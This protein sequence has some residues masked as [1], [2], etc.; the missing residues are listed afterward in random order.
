MFTVSRTGMAG[1]ACFLLLSLTQPFA[2]NCLPD[3]FPD[4]EPDPRN[5]NERK[6]ERIPVPSDVDVGFEYWTTD[7]PEPRPGEPI[8]L[9][10]DD[11]VLGE[12]RKSE[13]DCYLK[14]QDVGDADEEKKTDHLQQSVTVPSDADVGFEYWTNGQPQPRPGEPVYLSDEDHILGRLRQRK[15]LTR[16]QQDLDDVTEKSDQHS[17]AVPSDVDVGFEYWTNGQPQPSPGVPV[18]LLDDDDD[19]TLASRGDRYSTGRAHHPHHPRPKGSTDTMARYFGEVAGEEG[20]YAAG[21]KICE[22]NAPAYIPIHQGSPIME[23][24]YN[25]HN[26]PVY[27]NES[28][29]RIKHR[30][31]CAT[32]DSSVWLRRYC[33]APKVTC[34]KEDGS[35]HPWF[36]DRYSPD[37]QQGPAALPPEF[38]HDLPS[39]MKT[40][41]RGRD[42]DARPTYCMRRTKEEGEGGEKEETVVALEC[43]SWYGNYAHHCVGRDASQTS[44]WYNFSAR[45]YDHLPW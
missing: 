17:N 41:D 39:F 7:Q 28:E 30:F 36:Q 29:A 31:S 15:D 26:V 10:D 18:R 2:A 13:E 3:E 11:H 25:A 22:Y 37:G 23:A 42:R 5:M 4:P 16:G 45:S 43:R 44:G 21:K 20:F 40:V 34:T 1:L 33:N 38:C 35:F 12:V 32:L 24:I 9:L 19:W 6:Y 14:E 27:K 8:H